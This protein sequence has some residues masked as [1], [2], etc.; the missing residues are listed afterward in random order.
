M[1]QLFFSS[2]LKDSY[3]DDLENLLFFNAQQQQFRAE[4]I[5]SVETYGSPSIMKEGD[6]LRV[7][8]GQL[9]QVQSLFGFDSDRPDASLIGVILYF[10]EQMEQLTVL[11]IAVQS[12]YVATGYY[13]DQLLAVRLLQQVREVAAHIK[14]V[15][16][17]ALLYGDSRLRKIPVH[18]R[19]RQPVLSP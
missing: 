10:R 6:R 3:Y 15:N 18:H 17:V 2:V 16:S 5:Q 4:I 11:H 7:K 1:T 14:G 12:H 19:V 8:V 13:A 9:S